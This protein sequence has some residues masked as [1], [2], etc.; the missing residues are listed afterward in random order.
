MF[1]ETVDDRVVILQS[2]I[3]AS[4]MNVIHKGMQVVLKQINH[5][6]IQEPC[7]ANS[8]NIVGYNVV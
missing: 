1:P 4:N 8:L 3:W 7:I 2:E 5:M 6:V